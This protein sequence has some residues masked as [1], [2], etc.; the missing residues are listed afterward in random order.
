[1]LRRKK[2]QQKIEELNG[3]H[4]TYRKVSMASPW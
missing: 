3:D 1:M 4:F 2:A